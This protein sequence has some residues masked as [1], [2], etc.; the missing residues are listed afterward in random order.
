MQE[1]T[2]PVWERRA[3]EPGNWYARF[4]IYRLLGPTRT[5]ARAHRTAARLE[6]LHGKEPGHAW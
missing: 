1:E 5:L 4:E 6:G 2:V 3:G